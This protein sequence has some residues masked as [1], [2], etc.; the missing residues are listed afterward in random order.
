MV[1]TD[2]STKGSA[3]VVQTTNN[4]ELVCIKG[5][6]KYTAQAV[7]ASVRKAWYRMNAFEA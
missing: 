3:I 1:T 7:S 5:L 4:K 2:V 6:Q